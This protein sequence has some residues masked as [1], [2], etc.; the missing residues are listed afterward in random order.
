ML[1]GVSKELKAY[2]T[3]NPVTKKIVINKD[4]IFEEEASWD[5]EKNAEEVKLVVLVWEDEEGEE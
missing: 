4:T 3:Y 2:H 5:W 1:F